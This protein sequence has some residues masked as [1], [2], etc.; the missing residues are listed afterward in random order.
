V[1]EQ[2]THKPLVGG[3][4]PPSATSPHRSRATALRLEGR[5]DSFT[6]H[7]RAIRGPRPFVICDAGQDLCHG[8]LEALD[9]I[10]GSQG[11]ARPSPARPGGSS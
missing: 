11:D 8:V 1:V 2:G 6:M 3:S 4:N 10:L 7:Q 9:A 5:I